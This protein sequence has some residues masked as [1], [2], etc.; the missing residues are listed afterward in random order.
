M[1]VDLFGTEEKVVKEMGYAG[2][3]LAKVTKRRQAGL[4]P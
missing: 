1:T 2:C 3:R 4:K